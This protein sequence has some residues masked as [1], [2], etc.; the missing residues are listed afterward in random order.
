MKSPDEKS[1]TQEFL[2]QKISSE[3]RATNVGAC[4]FLTSIKFPFRMYIRISVV[5]CVY[6]KDISSRETIG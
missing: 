6:I 3:L 2:L 5:S 4:A 1:S